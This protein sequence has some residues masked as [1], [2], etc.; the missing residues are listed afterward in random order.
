M[1]EFVDV[2]YR[3]DR[4]IQRENRRHARDLEE[5]RKELV[6]FDIPT[7]DAKG[8][9]A[10]RESDQE[11]AI[12]INRELIRG[13]FPV[14]NGDL[15]DTKRQWKNTRH[16]EA[17]PI[18]LKYKSQEVR[19]AAFDAAMT[20]GLAGARLA[21][22]G[23]K[24]YG[25]IGFLRKSLTERERKNIKK[26]RE[27]RESP[28]GQAMKEILDREENSRTTEE[29]WLNIQLE[30]P[31]NEDD[32]EYRI[33]H[34]REPLPPAPTATVD[35][36]RIRELEALL[37]QER[38][39]KQRQALRD[40]ES[41]NNENNKNQDNLPGDQNNS[42]P[43]RPTSAVPAMMRTT[44]SENIT[45]NTQMSATPELFANLTG[46]LNLNNQNRGQ[47]RPSNSDPEGAQTPEYFSLTDNLNL[48]NQGQ[49]LARP[50]RTNP[51]GTQTPENLQP[52]TQAT[53]NTAPPGEQREDEDIWFT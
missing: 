25:R 5:T 34:G 37:A 18:T 22:P 19:D 8:E 35:Q 52:V 49:R 11:H 4:Q 24:Y 31:E 33:I 29:E 27:W 16:P 2:P 7:K 39:N 17:I 51:D 45:V 12:R 28:R 42:H 43:T 48:N 36:R 21:R 10:T 47:T 9:Y 50:N 26:N 53:S 23:D 32:E 44:A 40:Q 46:N 3:S 14:K 41:N 6:L 30:A 1:E 15:I 38:S 13:G 20:C